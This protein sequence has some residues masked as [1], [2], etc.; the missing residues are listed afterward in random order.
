MTADGDDPALPTVAVLDYGSGNVHSATRALSAAGAD[1]VLTA[2]PQVC[3]AADGLVVPGVGAFGACMDGLAAVGGPSL[4]LRRLAE[5][6]RC[7]ASASA[8]RCC[9]VSGSSTAKRFR[10][11]GPARRGGAWTL[12]L[13][14]GLEHGGAADRV[15]DVRR[16][17]GRRFY[18]V[19]STVCTRFSLPERGPGPSMV[20]TGSSPRRTGPAVVDPPSGKSGAAGGRLLRNW[21]DGVEGIMKS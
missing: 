13:P 17:G 15:G 21:L 20:V 5:K 8:T 12:S 11:W 10:G 14:H 7:W 9:S 1:V 6:R 2:D 18:F 4:I 16:G 19:H 3:L